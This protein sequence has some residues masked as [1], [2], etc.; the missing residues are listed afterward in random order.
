MRPA[1]LLLALLAL[2]QACAGS[3]SP[4][5]SGPAVHSFTAS[6]PALYPGETVLLTAVFSGGTGAV[7]PGIGPVQSGVPVILKP[8][9]RPGAFQ[10]TVTDGVQAATA[11]VALAVGYRHRLDLVAGA[12]PRTEHSAALLGD[13]RVLLGGGLFGAGWEGR[14]ERWDPLT[15]EFEPAGDLDVPH[16]EAATLLDG[17]G[18]VL[19]VG[20]NDAMGD[21]ESDMVHAFDPVTGQWTLLQPMAEIRTFHTATL[22]P[23]GLVLVAG[24]PFF[25]RDP[26]GVLDAEIYDPGGERPRAPRGGGMSFP[27]FGH[28]ATALPG[29]RILI[30]GGRGAFDGQ[31]VPAAELFDPETEAFTPIGSMAE[32]RALHVAVP[33][34][35]GRVLLAGGDTRTAT[36]TASAELFDPGDRTFTPTGAMAHGRAYHAA[37]PLATG[38]VLVAG[39]L[40]E[41]GARPAAIE[42]WD[43]ATRRFRRSPASLPSGRTG[44]AVVPLPDGAVLLHG[45]RIASGMADGFMGVYR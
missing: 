36:S 27:R 15:G 32:G 14:T 28:T 30:A 22:L 44:L 26:A 31:V 40:E 37:V 9:T 38:E 5:A 4:S 7:E 17:K 42:L 16:A 23:G 18:R 35:D 29:G 3:G 13:G 33:L 45:G 8:G 10:L 39:G 6:P 1:A 25:G 20:G 34:P 2:A 11:Q 43:P 24:G 12:I 19:V 41:D 21:L